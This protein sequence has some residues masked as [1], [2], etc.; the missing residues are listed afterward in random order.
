MTGFL[1]M[2]RKT[3]LPD[4]AGN[5]PPQSDAR[6]RRT[7]L[8]AHHRNGLTESVEDYIECISNLVGR[9]G[10]ASVSD[11]ADELDLMRPSVSLMIK[12]LA[13][14]GFLERKPYRG[15]VLT[16]RGKEVAVSIQRR[17]ALLTDLFGLLGL[18]PR[19]YR[20]DIEGLEHH[21]SERVF[22]RLTLL[23]AHL[24][25]HPLPKKPAGLSSRARTRDPGTSRP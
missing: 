18:V 22:D 10:F 14:L 2:A 12:R 7:K 20:A 1:P 8:S 19:R 21:I 3:T 25:R 16:A 11:V 23:V 4:S 6:G 5:P 13:D 9:N 17:H 15:F 24:L